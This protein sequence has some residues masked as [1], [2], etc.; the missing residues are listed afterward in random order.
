MKCKKR[1]KERKVY[2]MKKSKFT[3][4]LPV[5][6]AL[7]IM[8]PAAFA[9]PTGSATS[10][11]QITV[12]EFINITKVSEVN[13]T[14]ATFNDDYTT[15]TLMPALSATFKVIN[16]EPDKSV[17]LDGTA[18]ASDGDA[19]VLYGD[20]DA[21]KL[22]FVNNDRKPTLAQI[23]NITSGSAAYAD[24]PNAI[25]FAITASENF[26]PDSSSGAT[27]AVIS[28]ENNCAKYVISNGIYN[29]VYTIATSAEAQTFSTHDTNGLYKATLT[30]TSTQP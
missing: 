9:D 11:M 24:N 6:L 26:A 17:Y 12:P 8:S 1:K 5:A 15:I 3:K 22:V 18:T 28:F 16:N 7:M 4:I 10:E 29:P 2:P 19:K 13:E 21:M 30:L 20:K 14:E 23:Q 25:A 27:D